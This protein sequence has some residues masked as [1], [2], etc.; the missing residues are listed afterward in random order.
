MDRSLLNEEVDDY[1]FKLRD[2]VE[3]ELKCTLR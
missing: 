2:L 3:S 1:Q